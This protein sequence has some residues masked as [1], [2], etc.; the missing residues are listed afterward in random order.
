[1]H[2]EHFSMLVFSQVRQFYPP[3]HLKQLPEIRLNPKGQVEQFAVVLQV[4]SGLHSSTYRL[5]PPMQDVHFEGFVYKHSRHGS[6]H[7]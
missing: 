4:K 1:M 5:N 2:D 6:L 3:L 7:C